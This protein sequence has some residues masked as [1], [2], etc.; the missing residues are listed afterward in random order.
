MYCNIKCSIELDL[1]EF[2]ALEKLFF[3]DV[4]VL[5]PNGVATSASDVTFACSNDLFVKEIVR[6]ITN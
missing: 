4:T 5:V 2:D 1:I 6:P 3:D